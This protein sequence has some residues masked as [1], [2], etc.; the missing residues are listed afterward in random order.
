MGDKWLFDDVEEWGWRKVS[1]SDGFPPSRL[2]VDVR[3]TERGG[4][5]RERL[6]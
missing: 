5:E 4:N 1:D 3:M 6:S 2:R